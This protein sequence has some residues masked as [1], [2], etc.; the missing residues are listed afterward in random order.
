MKRLNPVGSLFGFILTILLFLGLGLSLW[1]DRGLAFNPGPITSISKDGVVLQGFTSHAEFEKQCNYCHEPLKTNLASKCNSC[2]EDV[3]QQIQFG[4]G[5][6]SRITNVDECSYCHT[7]HHGRTF[8][9]TLESYELFDHSKTGFS[10][11]WH[12]ENF[13]ATPMR[14]DECHIPEDFSVVTNQKCLECHTS[15]DQYFAQAHPQDFGTNCLGCHDGLDRMQKFDHLQTGYPLEGKHTQVK[16]IG[17]HISNNLNDAPKD[18]KGCHEEPTI[19]QGMFEQTCDT[20]HTTDSWTPANLANQ[21]FSHLSTA[22][23]SLALHKANYSDQV[24]TCA[25]CHPN[26]LQTTDIQTCIDCH[27]QHDQVFMADHQQQYGIDCRIC[28][29][30]VDRLS[31]FDH[32]NFFPLDGK[33]ESIQCTDCHT[34][35]VYRGAPTE[36]RQCHK[37]PE[38]HAGVFGLKC[39]YCHGTDAWSPA[40]LQQHNFPLNH[41][42]DDKNLQLECKTCHGDNYVAYTCY[43]CHDHQPDEIT[44][45][46]QAEGITEQ[47]LPACATCHPDGTLEENKTYP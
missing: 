29:D 26:D 22:G 47:G 17:C 7:E 4:Q 45:S 27:A 24:I 13:D 37:E 46:H 38:I 23:F 36:C 41:G 20:C 10:L 21:S 31:N 32:V 40:D 33:H 39:E 9:P 28:H 18:C 42:L 34:N 44:Q 8:N 15:H 14:C 2:H 5:V 11:N 25:G 35:N 6:H 19:H 30:G 3:N 1:I 43:N 16:C 12:Q